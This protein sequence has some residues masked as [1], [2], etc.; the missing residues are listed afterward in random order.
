MGS[1]AACPEAQTEKIEAGKMNTTPDA[2]GHALEVY[3]AEY[4]KLKTE[5]TQRIQFR[6][7][8]LMAHLTV[9]GAVVAYIIEKN[10]NPLIPYAYLVIPWTSSILGWAYLNN[11]IIISSIR[12]YL[13]N[14]LTPRLT[15]LPPDA[16][17]FG[18]ER[19]TLGQTSRKWRKPIQM[20]MDVTTFTIPAI[21]ALAR[22]SYVPWPKTH[23]VFPV[24]YGIDWL[25]TVL[26][27]YGLVRVNLMEN[28]RST[29][30]ETPPPST[31]PKDE[32]AS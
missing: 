32:T 15:M 29:V 12:D 10:D 18:W 20:I 19:H 30:A 17:A 4:D 23:A 8:L 7:N 11:D 2:S 16:L 28:R 14:T 5:Q 21:G 3:K 24:L 9:V 31:A 22:L 1:G 27:G 26:L 13:R 25:I 6:D